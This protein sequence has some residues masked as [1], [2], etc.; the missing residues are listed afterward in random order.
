MLTYLQI[1]TFG[2]INGALYALIGIGLSLVFGVMSYLNVAHGALI[3][4]AAYACF[5]LF[6][7][8]KVDPFVSVVFIAPAF[9]LLSKHLKCISQKLYIYYRFVP[10]NFQ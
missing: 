10:Q 5:W 4:G 8:Y 6:H 7:L 2:F 9:F 3:M 1:V